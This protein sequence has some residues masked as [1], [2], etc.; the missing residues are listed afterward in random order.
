MRVLY[1]R[2][3]KWLRK[4]SDQEPES[5]EDLGPIKPPEPQEE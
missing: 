1:N 2:F 5:L 3:A 4:H